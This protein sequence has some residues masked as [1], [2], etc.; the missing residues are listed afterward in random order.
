M[1]KTPGAFLLEVKIEKEANIFPM[2][3]A[4]TS[5]SDVILEKM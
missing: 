5:V 4:G 2:V 3:A 1:L